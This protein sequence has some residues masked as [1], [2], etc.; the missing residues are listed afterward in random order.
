MSFSSNVKA[1]LAKIVPGND[2]CKAAMAEARKYFTLVKKAYKIDDEVLDKRCCRRAFLRQAFLI[3]G[4]MSDPEKS[5]HFEIVCPLREKAETI[6][7]IIRT[8]DDMNPKIVQRGS[9]YI[10]YLKGSDQIVD[11]MGIMEAPKSFMELENVR[12]LKGMR[13]DVN[14]RVNCET[15]NISKTISAAVRQIEDIKFIR[16]K[17]GFSKLPPQLSEMAQVRL[18]H[19]EASLQELGEYLDPPI[20]KSGVNHR[21]RRLSEYARDIGAPEGGEGEVL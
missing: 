7:D 17:V 15:A 6:R 3:A 13:N 4:T 12:I 19:P 21:M 20:G 10:V 11:M 18:E 16:D 14:R 5:Y 9:S 8:F 2:H 1:E